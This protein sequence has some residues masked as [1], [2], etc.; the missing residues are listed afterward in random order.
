LKFAEARPLGTTG[1][2]WLKIHLSNIYGFDKAS[3]EE[4]EEWTMKHL[5]QIRDSAKK[6][7]E[8]NLI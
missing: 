2:R 7:L 4:R 8:V 6:P 1:L 5:E 3:F